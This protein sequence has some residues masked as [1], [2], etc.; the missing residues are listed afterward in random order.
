M[1]VMGERRVDL[2]GFWMLD[3]GIRFGSISNS[4]EGFAFGSTSDDLFVHL[5]VRS[6]VTNGKDLS[7]GS[8]IQIYFQCSSCVTDC[9]E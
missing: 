6:E 2:G 1:V 5:I 9:E 4:G 8:F 7:R 3:R